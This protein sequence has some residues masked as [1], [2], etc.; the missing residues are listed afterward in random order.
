MPQGNSFR[1]SRPSRFPH[2]CPKSTAFMMKARIYNPTWA[3]GGWLVKKTRSTDNVPPVV[4]SSKG[5]SFAPQNVGLDD[6]PAT[7]RSTLSM[8][9]Q[10]PSRVAP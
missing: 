4:A 2:G 6:Q 10:A 8:D 1:E 5:C 9:K 7:A 3:M